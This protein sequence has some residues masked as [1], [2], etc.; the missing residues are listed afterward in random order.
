MVLLKLGKIQSLGTP[1]PHFAKP[2]NVTCNATLKIGKSRNLFNLM[3]EIDIN[4]DFRNDSICGDPDTDSP[5]LYENHKIL[6]SKNL[7]C[8]RVLNLETLTIGGKYGRIVLK[9]N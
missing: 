1:A 4:F 3:T 9:N 5:K 8:T 7:P 2:T 6:W